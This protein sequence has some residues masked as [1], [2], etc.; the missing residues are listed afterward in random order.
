MISQ[1]ASSIKRATLVMSGKGGVGKST[2]A[3]QLATGLAL[4]GFKVGL[5]DVDICGPS[6]ARMLGREEADILQTDKGWSPVK[7]S[8]SCEL[9]LM[10]IAYLTTSRDSAI[11]WRGPKKHSMIERFISGVN[12]GQLDELIIDT[13]PGTSDEHISLVEL[14]TKHGITI[15]V[16][17]VTTPQIVACN[18]VRREIGFCKASKVRVAGLVENMSGFTCPNCSECSNIFSSKGGQEL[19]KMAELNFLGSIP[20]DPNLCQCTES[21]RNFIEE[22]KDSNAAQVIDEIVSRILCS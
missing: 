19:C 1:Q 14:L 7:V 2:V 10:S 12:W 9:Y 17:L 16:I 22:F 6:L 13:P 15:Q 18:D 8:E 4:K 3:S 11:I 21:G 5:L 20:I